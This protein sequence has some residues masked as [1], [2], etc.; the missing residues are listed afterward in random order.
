MPVVGLGVILEWV[1]PAVLVVR[2][3]PVVLTAFLML[4]VAVVVA[5]LHGQ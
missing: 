4:L 3:V 2:V 1:V 5:A